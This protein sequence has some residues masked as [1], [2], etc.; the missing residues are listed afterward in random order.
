MAQSKAIS[1]GKQY[2]LFSDMATVPE[3]SPACGAEEWNL[4]INIETSTTNLP[5]C[6]NPDLP[7]WL[8]IDEVSKQMAFSWNGVLDTDAMQMF[9][10]WWFEGGPKNVRW[11]T[12]GAALDGGGYYAGPALLTSYSETAT[13]GQKWRISAGVAIDGKP[14]HTPAA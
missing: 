10:D 5:D 13:R 12:S 7:A 1:F 11:M 3:F 2:L 14:T 6:E 4:N 8:G 9:R